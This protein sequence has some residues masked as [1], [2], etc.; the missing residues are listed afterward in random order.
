MTTATEPVRLER[1]IPGVGVLEF[2]ESEKRRDYWLRP[3]GN[4]RRTRLPSVTSILRATWPKPGLL[5]WYAREGAGVDSALEQA[6][7]RGRAV[8][9][10]VEVF[11]TT[12]DI[13]PF[14]DFPDEY[15]PY[16][17]AV[18]R[19]LWEYDPKPLAVEQLVCHPELNYAGRLDL[20]ASMERHMDGAP[21]LLDFK[22][23]TRGKVYTEAH[24]QTHAYAVGEKRCGGIEVA[25]TMLVGVGA[26]GDYHVVPGADASKIWGS[27][28]DFYKTISRFE[29]ELDK[30]A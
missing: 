23:N 12:G 27:I 16:L 26:D 25:G 1:A 4:T 7:R 13:L 14:S 11:M 8:H 22:S 21:T 3:E 28:L 20:I 6:S 15:A 10:F 5:E 2:V 18:A 29:K 19:F 30:A 17:T 24:I 9:N